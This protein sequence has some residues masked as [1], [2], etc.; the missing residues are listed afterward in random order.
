MSNKSN[1]F[2]AVVLTTSGESINRDAYANA[3]TYVSGSEVDSN[4]KGVYISVRYSDRVENA[5]T[6]TPATRKQDEF[7]DIN[8]KLKKLE[9]YI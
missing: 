9:Q 7:L 8:A 6:Y 4:I 3:D 5:V 2:K 1:P